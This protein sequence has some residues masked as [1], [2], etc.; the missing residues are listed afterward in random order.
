MILERSIGSAD[1]KIMNQTIQTQLNHRSI[2]KYKETPIPAETLQQILEVANRTASSMMAQS[3]SIIRV[4]DSTIKEKISEICKQEFIKTMPELF[5]FIVDAYRNAKLV[6]EQG[7]DFAGSYDVDRFFQAFTDG[8]LAA[9]NVMTAV[10]SLGLGAVYLGSTL[11]NVP[12]MIELLGLPKYTFPI[13]GLGFGYP[14]EDP[15]L[16]PRMEMELKVFENSYQ[17]LPSY[18]EAV[19]N[20]NNV[21]REYYDQR[22]ETKGMPD[23]TAKMKARA[24]NPNPMRNTLLQTI[25]KQGFTLNVNAKEVE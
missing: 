9:Q 14:D 25:Q 24:Q 1:K 10:E 22:E 2:R 18:T 6:E 13:V 21:L 23:F 11:N 7:Q 20:Y 3:F 15:S 19:N 5:I 8:C 17:V 12:A 4:T 16:K